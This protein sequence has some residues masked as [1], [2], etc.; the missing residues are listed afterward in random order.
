MRL[1]PIASG[2]SGNCIYVGNDSTHLLIDAGIS[3]KRIVEGLQ[4]I[5]IGVKDLQ[6]ILVTH[7][8]SDH[9]SALGI[10]SRKCHVPIYATKDTIQAMRNMKS[11]G[12]MDDSLYREIMPDQEFCINNLIINP[13]HISHDAA[14]P[15]AYCVSEGEKKLAVVTDLGCYDDYTISRLKEMDVLMIEANHNVK[16]LQVGSYPYYLKQRILGDLGH[17]S[18]EI[19]G[20]L[21]NEVLHDDLQEIILG[22]LSQEN[23]HE[24]IAYETVRMEVTM[25]EHKYKGD[26]FK[27]TVAKRTSSTEVVEI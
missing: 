3:G 13:M 9:I 16:M 8:H 24:E 23:N 26:D 22:H 1:A 10:M 11:L 19:C 18:N 21:I 7:E 27:I 25:G 2:S 14:N 15:V 5:D 12:N 20:Q 6:G 17:L 4:A